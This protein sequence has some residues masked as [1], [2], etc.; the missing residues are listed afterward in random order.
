MPRS[1]SQ[2]RRVSMRRCQAAS[3]ASVKGW[4]ARY[5]ASASSPAK[6]S[7]PDLPRIT[8]GVGETPRARRARL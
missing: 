7:Q 8:L 5:E 3:S 4:T 6:K 2:S 1:A